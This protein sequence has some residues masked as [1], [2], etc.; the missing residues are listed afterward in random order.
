MTSALH[1]QIWMI[2]VKENQPKILA[3]SYTSFVALYKPHLT[4]FHDYNVTN[5]VG[6][7]WRNK[8]KQI[9]CRNEYKVCYVV[10]AQWKRAITMIVFTEWWYTIEFNLSG[11]RL[12]KGKPEI[13]LAGMIRTCQ[14]IDSSCFI[15]PGRGERHREVKEFPQG[16]LV[17]HWLK[18]LRQ[19]LFLQPKF[20]SSKLK[21]KY[22]GAK[23]RTLNHKITNFHL[24]C[25]EQKSMEL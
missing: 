3:L 21:A 6:I 14:L 23:G 10:W 15:L 2:V 22:Q 8:R 12:N 25:T 4:C 1:L 13:L 9:K 11:P 7:K 24:L 17:I 5:A 18:T 19:N 16:H 20:Y